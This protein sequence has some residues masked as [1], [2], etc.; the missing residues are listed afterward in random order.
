MSD[1][2]ENADNATPLEPD[3][4]RDLLQSW[5]TTRADLNEAEQ[6]NILAGRQWAYRSRVKLTDGAYLQRL[7]HR[8]FGDVW[9]WAGELRT[10]EVNI[11]GS[12]SYE[13]PARLREFLD[14]TQ[15]WIEHATYPADELAVRYHHGL[16]L[17]HPFTNGN[18]RHTRLAAELL[19]RRLGV[20][21]FTWGRTSLD[22]NSRVRDRYIAALKAA[23]RYDL[24]PLLAFA[25]L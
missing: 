21:A 22:T 4:Q 3:A 8:M 2:L 17:I 18:G 9:R 24:A 11:G 14:N 10:I 13:V 5:I 6:A 7:H 16:V 20:P 23:D 15:Y 25:R 1:L 19:C 12:K